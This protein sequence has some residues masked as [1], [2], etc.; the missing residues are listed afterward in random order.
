MKDFKFFATCSKGLEEVLA[1]ELKARN[2]P[3]IEIDRGGVRFGKTL[4]DGY[5]ACL[6]SRVA[7]RVLLEL[8]V[9]WIRGADDLYASVKKIPWEDHFSVRQSFKVEFQGMNLQIRNT[10]FGS[11]K[12]KDAVV[13]RFR[14]K[15][16]DRPDVKTEQA[17]WVLNVHMGREDRG[18]SLCSIALDLSG[19]SLHERGYR[20]QN[21]AAPLKE[22]LAA[23]VLALSDWSSISE[24]GGTFVDFMCGSGTI[25][26]EAAMIATRTAPGLNRGRYSFQSWR[27]HAPKIWEELLKEAEETRVKDLKK[28]PPIVGYDRDHRAVSAAIGN[29]DRAGFRGIVHIEKRE[30]STA[31]PPPIKYKV[32]GSVQ[33]LVAVNPPY[34]ER[35]GDADLNALYEKM[36]DVLKQKFAGF[37]ASLLTGN[38]EAAKHIG[39]APE[40]RIPLYNGAIE[41]RLLKYQLYAGKLSLSSGSSGAS[42]D[43]A[44]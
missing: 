33:G 11:L 12:V 25:P 43:S 37:K 38:A 40:R 14:Y 1:Q 26:I 34:G 23:G 31:A 30:L 9:D 6:W 36:G 39:L 35:I 41:C 22:T 24:Q 10:H 15:T 42:E 17:D 4:R 7:Q 3:E 16:G 8:K 18:K 27:G 2:I 29:V 32:S 28:I 20:M 5:A 21:V 44:S 13:D 19:H